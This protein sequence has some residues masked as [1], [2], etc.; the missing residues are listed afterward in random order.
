MKPTGAFTVFAK[1]RRVTTAVDLSGIIRS[2]LNGVNEAGWFLGARNDNKIYFY[3]F[4]VSWAYGYTAALSDAN[5]WYWAIATHNPSDDKFRLYLD[6]VYQ[7]ISSAGP[8]ADYG[9]TQPPTIGEYGGIEW[10]GDIAVAGI[11]HKYWNADMVR[12]FVSNPYQFL[13][14]A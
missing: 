9:N 5:R 6:D 2:P 11:T 8:W 14:P 7:W 13:I 4:Q 12:R 3:R 1:V 10:A